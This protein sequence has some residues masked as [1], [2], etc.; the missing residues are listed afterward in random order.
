MREAVRVLHDQGLGRR[1]IALRLGVSKGTVGFHVRRLRLPIDERFARR[2]DWSEIRAAYDAGL[3]LRQCRARFGFTAK[4]WYDAIE[5]GDIVPR[6]IAVPIEELLVATRPQTNRCHLKNRLLKERLK[7]NRC[8]RCGITDW[9]GAPLNMQLHHVN[10]DGKD[11]R[12][13]NI[14]LLCGNCH[15]QTPNYGGRNGHRRK[16]GRTGEKEAL[17][18]GR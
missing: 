18:N 6:P 17:Q 10:G 13:E 12:L 11:N 3:S 15:S 9:M 4:A 2:Y 5:R 14:E 1:D 16:A 8:E 7:E